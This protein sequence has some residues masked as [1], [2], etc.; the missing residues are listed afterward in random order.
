MSYESKTTVFMS[1]NMQNSDLF[2]QKC[3]CLYFGDDSL[4]PQIVREDGKPLVK[5]LP[6]F[7]SLSHSGDCIVVA[8]SNSAVGVDVERV[9]EVDYQS[10][11]KRFFERQPSSLEEFFEMW[12]AKEAIK[13]ATNIS[14]FKA[15]KSADYTNIRYIDAIE[16]YKLALYG[17]FSVFSFQ[18]SVVMVDK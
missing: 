15:L 11:A 14:L 7:V 5:N 18:F 8:V 17:E 9:R 10:I 2:L 6:V 4:C 3:I 16:G 12:T 13:K 1:R